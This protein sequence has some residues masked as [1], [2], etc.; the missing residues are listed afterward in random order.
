[1]AIGLKYGDWGKVSRWYE[2]GNWGGKMVFEGQIGFLDETF[3]W[4]Q[5]GHQ[6]EIRHK[7][8]I[9]HLGEISIWVKIHHLAK[10]FYG[11]E[12]RVIFLKHTPASCNLAPIPSAEYN[13]PFAKISGDI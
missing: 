10:W 13:S 2:T 9:G 12:I 1:M 7:R 6:T 8:K 3:P 4:G 11:G 5:I